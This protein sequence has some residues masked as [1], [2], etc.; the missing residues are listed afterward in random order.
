MDS[1]HC[2]SPSDT[3]IIDQPDEESVADD[4]MSYQANIETPSPTPLEGDEIDIPLTRSTKEPFQLKNSRK[5]QA[6]EEY[7]L[8][9]GLAKSMSE[10]KNK[11]LKTDNKQKNQ[12]D[13]FGRY[14]SY[15][16]AELE[17]K[18]RFVAQH[19]INN[20]LFQ[21]Q[22]GELLTRQTFGM[23]TPTCSQDQTFWP[24]NHPT[25]R[26]KVDDIVSRFQSQ[27]NNQHYSLPFQRQHTGFH[28][29]LQVADNTRQF[30]FS[31]P[32]IQSPSN[33]HE[34]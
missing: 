34:H 8:I 32:S 13:T 6:E 5:K 30:Q 7:H 17:P 4:N 24:L 29:T 26:S 11:K 18:V 20:I 14:V 33:V 31:S 2:D 10:K 22:S 15:T 3:S 25:N 23:V 27:L 12:T 9:K 16:L 21:A 28:P 19:H 1:E